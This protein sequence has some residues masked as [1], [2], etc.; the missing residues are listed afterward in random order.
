MPR[1]S[2]VSL[3]EGYLGL[4]VAVAGV[5]ELLS[6]STPWVL[7]AGVIIWLAAAAI[8]ITGIVKARREL[9]HPRPAYCLRFMLLHDTIH[10]RPSG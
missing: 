4:V 5:I 1:L 3:R 2:S 10:A 6:G 8:T 9:P 7:A